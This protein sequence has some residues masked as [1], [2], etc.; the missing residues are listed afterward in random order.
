MST[1]EIMCDNIQKNP[2]LQV[3]FFFT[4]IR[5]PAETPDG[6]KKCLKFEM[7]A[8]KHEAVSA[9]VQLQRLWCTAK[10]CVLTNNEK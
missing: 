3:E 5:G 4:I 1:M 8:I 7:K 10:D 2:Q 9:D 6:R